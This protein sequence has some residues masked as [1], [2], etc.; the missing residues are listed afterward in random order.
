[1]RIKNSLKNFMA[2]LGSTL[3]SSILAFVSRTIFIN[4]LGE[5]Y[6]GI[7]GLLTN[8]LSML[9]LAELGI[10]TAINFSLYKPIAENDEKKIS[11]LMNFYKIVKVF[12]FILI[13]LKFLQ[14]WMNLHRF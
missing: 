8:V 9:S 1:M 4:I 6:L 7:N 10:G 13:R 11:I 2:G 5:A 14:I 3:I 12:K